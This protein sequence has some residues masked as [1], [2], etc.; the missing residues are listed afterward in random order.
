M[1]DGA[2]L[3]APAT[4]WRVCVRRAGA[5]HGCWPGYDV[6]LIGLKS[7]ARLDAHGQNAPLLFRLQCPVHDIDLGAAAPTM[8]WLVDQKVR[9]ACLACPD[10]ERQRHPDGM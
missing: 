10:R 4:R 6:S 1:D 9:F 2:R 8:R 7:R 3:P 5:V